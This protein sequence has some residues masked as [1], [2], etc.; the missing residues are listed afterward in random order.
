MSPCRCCVLGILI[1]TH[2]VQWSGRT[3]AGP[4]LNNFLPIEYTAN[5][6]DDDDD[7]DQYD[8]Y[9][10]DDDDDDDDEGGGYGAP[11]GYGFVRPLTHVALARRGAS[12]CRSKPGRLCGKCSPR[13]MRT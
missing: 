7:E 6:D 13:N 9:G 4:S 2:T 12:V 1:R 11:Y 8:G 3:Q 5:D 10:Q